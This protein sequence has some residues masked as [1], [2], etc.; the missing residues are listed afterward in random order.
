MTDHFIIPFSEQIKAYS[1]LKLINRMDV[2]VN[3]V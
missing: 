1:L 2:A 3:E